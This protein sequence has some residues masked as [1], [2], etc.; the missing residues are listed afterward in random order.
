MKVAI[1][2]AGLSG[3]SC[4]I[5]LERHGIQ[6]TIFEK[7]SKVGDRFIN[8]E[9]ILSMMTRSVEDPIRYLSEKYQIYLKPSS[10]INKMVIRSANQKTTIHEQLGYINIRGRHS[11]SFENQLAEQVKSEINFH[12]E[13]SYEE[14]LHEYT[15]VIV[16]TGDGEYVQRMNNYEEDRSV[17]LK[18]ATV[19]GDFDISTVP[20]WLDYSLAPQGYG[21]LLPFSKNEANIVIGIPDEQGGKEEGLQELWDRYFQRVCTDLQQNLHVTDQFQI[22]NYKIGICKHPRIGNT[23]FTGNCFGTMMPFL[24]FGQFDAILTG[25]YAGLDL[26]GKGNY[27]KLTKGI[28][29]DYNYSLSLRRGMERLN[30]ESLD[31]MVRGLDSSIGQKLFTRSSRNPLRVIS[32]LLRPFL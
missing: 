8:G 5:M 20:V 25:V 13:H 15:H 7:R 14:L 16:A 21:Y 28:R 1:M 17:T 10:N 9:S 2:G 26:C 31:V 12:S 4:A 27:E 6:P 11:L 3:L 22:K 30:N 19:E 23:L 29:R 24:G 32:Y 18:G